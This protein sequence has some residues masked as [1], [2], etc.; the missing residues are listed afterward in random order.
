MKEIS[1]IVPVYNVEEYLSECLNSLVNQTIKEKLEVI[2]VNDGSTDNSQKI[3][4]EYV[5]KYPDLFTSYIKENGGLSDAR[6]YGMNR[7]NCEYI[8]FL[9]SDDYMVKDAYEK[10]LKKIKEENLD[11]VFFDLKWFYP[12]GK[13]EHRS[14]IPEFIKNETMETK[15]ILSNPAACN[16]II[17]RECFNDVKFIEKIWYEDLA[18][19]PLLINKTN[20]IGYLNQEL[21]MY[22][23]RLNSIMSKNK[24]DTRLLDI[25]KACQ[26][27]YTNLIET[28]YKD[29]LEYLYIFQLIYYA[30][31]RFMEFNKYDDI[32][33]CI[34]E[35]KDK[36]PNWKENKFYKMKPF[37]FKI[38]CSLLEKKQY[39][40]I[41][42]L[43]KL[44][45]NN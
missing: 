13:E 43:I 7:T 19:L 24:Y 26:N 8:T 1:V 9:D 3:I 35:L 32:Q 42:L 44:R 15:Y 5:E 25:I 16:K 33:K 30:S 14:T 29:E 10:V 34:N 41:K 40:L 2:V 45:G 38:Y 6:N 18:T 12:D 36:F 17:K 11:I 28:K 4:D 22:R 23:Q 20:K 37:L 21:Y 27:L 31:F 39:T